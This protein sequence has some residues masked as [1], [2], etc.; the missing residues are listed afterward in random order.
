MLDVWMN[1]CLSCRNWEAF[2]NEPGV[3][4]CRARAPEPGP[5]WPDSKVGTV[6]PRTGK[7][8]WCGMWRDMA[9]VGS[10]PLKITNEEIAGLIYQETHRVSRTEGVVLPNILTKTD[11]VELIQSGRK[12]SRTAILQRLTRLIRM[13]KVVEFN[14]DGS[15]KDPNVKLGQLCLAVSEKPAPQVVQERHEAPAARGRPSFDRMPFLEIL[16][17]TMKPGDPKGF[18]TLRRILSEWRPVAGGT[19]VRILEDLIGAGFLT[20]NPEGKY[21]LLPW[22]ESRAPEAMPAAPGASPL[23]LE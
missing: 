22:A 8:D 21:V 18:A 16:R 15:Q 20:K 19:L 3:G 6:W 11:C 10:R 1:T 12:I 14:Y 9:A 4:Y 7:L 23:D 17:K 2:E 13:G 5:G